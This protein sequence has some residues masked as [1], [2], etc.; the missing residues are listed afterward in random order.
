MIKALLNEVISVEVGYSMKIIP[1]LSLEPLSE[2][3]YFS[4][5]E[6]NFNPKIS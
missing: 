2:T 1:H 6:M 3:M 5:D 4:T